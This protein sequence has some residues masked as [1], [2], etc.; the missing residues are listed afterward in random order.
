[1]P[2]PSKPSPKSKP[3]S[4]AAL[5]A[6]SKADVE[7]RDAIALLTADHRAVARLFAAFED[8]TGDAEKRRLANDICV[9]LKVHARLEEDLFYPAALGAVGDPAM[10][11]EAMVEHA[12]ARDL[13]AQVESGA[14]GQA[15]F[16]ARV[17]VLGEYVQ[18]HVAEEEEEI[19]PL[20]RASKL[21]LEAL[22]TRLALRKNELNVGFKVSNPVLALT[23]GDT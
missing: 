11:E 13:I 7:G 2:R 1:M 3:N 18:H 10:I 19:F 17:K 12:S 20:C 15:L 16:D 4:K 23:P 9:A 21:D 22:G 14:P 8:A 6:K 5:P